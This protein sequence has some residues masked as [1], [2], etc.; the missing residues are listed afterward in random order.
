MWALA[1]DAMYK[2]RSESF[3]KATMTSLCN[4]TVTI[5][6]SDSRDLAAQ[7]RRVGEWQRVSVTRLRVVASHWCCAG[8]GPLMSAA[9][10][11]LSWAFV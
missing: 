2:G 4:V 5:A 3:A 11:S 8:A 10:L 9:V 6:K 7:G 1:T